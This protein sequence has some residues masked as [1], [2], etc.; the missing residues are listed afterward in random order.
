MS[1]SSFHHLASPFHSL[2]VPLVI[3]LAVVFLPVLPVLPPPFFPS[4]PLRQLVVHYIIPTYRP[5]HNLC[6]MNL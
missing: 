2:H 5:T 6:A 4:P 1:L 3:S